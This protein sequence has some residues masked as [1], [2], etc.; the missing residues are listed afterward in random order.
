MRIEPPP[1]LADDVLVGTIGFPMNSWPFRTAG[2]A[3]D[4]HPAWFGRGI[5]TRYCCRAVTD[6]AIGLPGFVRVQATTLDTDLASRRLIE[7]SG[8]VHEGTL[9]NPKM[10]RGTPRDFHLFARMS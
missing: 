6:W 8:F 1:S 2:V 4:V 10:V 5:A 9:T 7:K 3:Y